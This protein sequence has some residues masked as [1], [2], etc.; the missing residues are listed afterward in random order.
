MVADLY[1]FDLETFV[2]QKVSPHPEDD[3]P[4][5]RYFHS[6]DACECAILHVQ[7]GQIPELHALCDVSCRFCF[8]FGAGLN[9][10]TISRE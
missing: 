8:M 7:C 4:G 2:W 10:M 6:A 9:Y 5:A 1:L 3:V